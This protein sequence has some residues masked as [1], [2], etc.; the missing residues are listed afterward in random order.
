MA[1]KSKNSKKI[2]YRNVKIEIISG[3]TEEAIKIGSKG[4]ESS[5]DADTGTYVCDELPYQTFGT[6][7]E[8]GKAFVDSEDSD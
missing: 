7:E 2:E 8:L 4:I 1:R 6:L 3:Q 5:R